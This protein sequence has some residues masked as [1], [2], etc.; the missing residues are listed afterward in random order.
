MARKGSRVGKPGGDDTG[1]G[2]LKPGLPP[3]NEGKTNKGGMKKD[4]RPE[5]DETVCVCT[6]KN[7]HPKANCIPGEPSYSAYSTLARPYKDRICPET[8]TTSRL[9][10]SFCQE[11]G[12]TIK[13]KVRSK[14]G[15]IHL[16]P[17][18]SS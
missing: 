5:P 1:K 16:W 12:G 15:G 7:S 10:F 13:F 17:W 4:K 2:G 3:K 6:E 9:A 8:A 18:P 11:K 14:R